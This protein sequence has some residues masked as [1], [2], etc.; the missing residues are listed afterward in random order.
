MEK[1]FGHKMVINTMDNF[2][3]IKRM[4]MVILFGQVAINIKVYFSK[5]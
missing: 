2:L 3:M 5:I 4:V 1:V